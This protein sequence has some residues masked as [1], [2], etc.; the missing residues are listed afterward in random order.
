MP[1]H[2]NCYTVSCYF[3]FVM[4]IYLIY[5]RS[6]NGAIVLTKIG[7]TSF[8]IFLGFSDSLIAKLGL[9]IHIFFFHFQVIEI[10]V[11]VTTFPHHGLDLSSRI[12]SGLHLLVTQL[13]L[14]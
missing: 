12:R 5:S 8:A 1:F 9:S 3:L 10:I 14:N 2:L 13:K 11:T 6:R 7:L 4:I